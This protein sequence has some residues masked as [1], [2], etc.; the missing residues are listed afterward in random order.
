VQSAADLLPFLEG[1]IGLYQGIGIGT[2]AALLLVLRLVVPRAQRRQLR[3]PVVLLVVH[4]VLLC[5]LGLLPE[6][7]P[8]DS[9]APLAKKTVELSA[10]SVLLLSIARSFYL[11]LLYALLRRGKKRTLP[12]IFRDII[13]VAFYA[14]VALVVLNRA[15]VEPGSLLTTSALLTAV[16]G[17]SLQD[18]LGNLFAGL[19][20]QAQQ[21]FE[22]GDWI[23][24]DDDPDHI[25]EILEINW[26]AARMLTI[27]R[28]EVTV[29][30]SL[31]A[32]APIRN[33]SKP[34]RLVRRNATVLAPYDAPPARVHRL[35]RQAV[36]EVDGVRSHPPPDIQTIQFTERGVEYRVRYFIEEF[37]QREVIDSRVRDR[38]WYALR[39]AALPIPPP[40][41]RVT[42]IEHNAATAEAEHQ[43]K[44][45]DVERSLEQVPLLSPLPH[46]LLHEVAIHTERRLY[47]PGELVIQQ[48]DHGEELFIVE[49]GNVEVLVDVHDG[50]QHVATLKP[51]QFFGEM[52]L[53]T[54]EQRK[55]TVRTEGEVTLLVVSKESL[56]PI[57]EAS[58]D[59]AHEISDVLAERELQLGRHSNQPESKN[60]D[61]VTQRRGE[62]LG[63]IREFFSI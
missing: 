38:L 40:Q 25:G 8:G 5:L 15:G 59:L 14:I 16:I 20:I 27:D 34:T 44:V 11:L 4:L 18:T 55:A 58:P 32:K 49:K 23:Q 43:A 50:M 33:Y 24:F 51:G 56:Q 46:D 60:D 36:V 26:R 53:M 42:L 22:V 57:L 12:G 2:A 48:G 52:S 39:R 30:N 1:G 41:R 35:M 29:P 37:D 54:G 61:V 3:A 17:L 63:R 7:H 31:L 6:P 10:L 19:A 47:A 9:F 62:L 28:I 21:P 13:Q 45:V